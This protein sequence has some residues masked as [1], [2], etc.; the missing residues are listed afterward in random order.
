MFN[1]KFMRKKCRKK[2]PSDFRFR[3]L[4]VLVVR[5][6]AFN[7]AARFMMNAFAN[8]IDMALQQRLTF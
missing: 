5:G 2:R 8:L 7:T 6:V 4:K 1:E 3:D